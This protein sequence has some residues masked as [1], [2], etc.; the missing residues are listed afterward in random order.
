M[1]WWFVLERL[2]SLSIGAMFGCVTL[3]VAL[4]AVVAEG[5]LKSALGLACF[6]LVCLTA[7][8][9]TVPREA[10]RRWS[11]AVAEKKATHRAGSR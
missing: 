1:R 4:L 9:W 10:D 2:V 5:R 8:W 7:Y 11:L 3:D 6:A